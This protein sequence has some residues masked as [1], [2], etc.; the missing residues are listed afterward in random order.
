MSLYHDIGVIIS[1]MGKSK[2][3]SDYDLIDITQLIM[4]PIELGQYKIYYDAMERPAAF[5][6][7][8]Y[9]SE[10]S[11][12]NLFKDEEHLTKAEWSSGNILYISD[13]AASEGMGREYASKLVKDLG[14]DQHGFSVRRDQDGFIRR[15]FYWKGEDLDFQAFKSYIESFYSRFRN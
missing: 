4:P 1:L 6:T 11:L 14:L 13:F 9:L 3:Y 7:W 15:V 10:G 5:A 2:F 8:A 12:N